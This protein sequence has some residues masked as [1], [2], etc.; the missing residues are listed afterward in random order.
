[1]TEIEQSE[2]AEDFGF[3]GDEMQDVVFHLERAVE[4]VMKHEH[5]WLDAGVDAATGDRLEDRCANALSVI[6]GLVE[7][8]ARASSRI[9]RVLETMEE[10]A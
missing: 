7:T 3:A 2:I 10:E 5:E 1:M 8:I 9:D 6:E 4:S